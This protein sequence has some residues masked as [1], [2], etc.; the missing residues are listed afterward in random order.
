MF[1][2]HNNTEYAVSPI[3][4]KSSVSEFSASIIV[5]VYKALF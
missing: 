5:G 2:M 4:V 1:A 3:K